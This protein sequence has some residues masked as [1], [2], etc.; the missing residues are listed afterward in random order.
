MIPIARTSASIGGVRMTIVQLVDKKNIS[1][2]FVAPANSYVIHFHS[3]FHTFSNF[4]FQQLR[5]EPTFRIEIRET[6]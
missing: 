2:F 4:V 3:F 6:S 1:M 5:I